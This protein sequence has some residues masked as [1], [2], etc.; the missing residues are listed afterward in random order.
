MKM[1]LLRNLASAMISPHSY[2]IQFSW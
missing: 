1:M 2:I